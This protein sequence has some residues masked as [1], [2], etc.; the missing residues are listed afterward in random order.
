MGPAFLQIHGDIPNKI[1]FYS[2]NLQF[3]MQRDSNR[4][5]ALE[6]IELLFKMAEKSE[7]KFADRYVYLAR[8]IAMRFNLKIPENL[9]RKFCHHCY[10]YFKPD[11]VTVRTNAKNKAIE[12]TCSACSKVTRYGYGR[13]KNK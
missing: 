1:V 11:R 6:R 12:H 10:I 4:K 5:I 7:D 13:K 3:F 9:K 8:K 2:I